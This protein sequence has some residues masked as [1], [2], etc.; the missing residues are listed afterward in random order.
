M[1]GTHFAYKGECN[2]SEIF[3]FASITAHVILHKYS[4][5]LLTLWPPSKGELL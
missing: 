2:E 3:V 5:I 4:S 1:W